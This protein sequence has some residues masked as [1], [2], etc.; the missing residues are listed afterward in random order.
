MDR[1]GNYDI[2]YRHVR[3][4]ANN[5]ADRLARR[6]VHSSAID[7]LIHSYNRSFNGF[8]AKLTDQ[9]QRKIASTEGVVSVFPS[10]IYKPL[11]TRSWDF[12]GFKDTVKRMPTIESDV[13]IGVLDT[14]ISPGSES[15]DDEGFGPPPK[16]W[17]GKCQ[18]SKN[19]ACNKKLIGARSYTGDSPIDKEGHGT[20][21]SSTAAG[22]GV[23]GA[24]LLGLAQGTARGAVPSARIAMYKVCGPDG[25]PDESIL[26][27]FDDAIADG[28]DILSVSLGLT[29]PS[30]YRNDSIAI[31]SF[32]AMNKGILT[33]QSAGNEGPLLGSVGS[34]A[35]WLLTVAATSTDRRI[36]NKIVL[37]NGITLVGNA[38]NTFKLNGTM[39]PLI[40]GGDAAS[41]N[42]DI[43]FARS[44]GLGCLDKKLVKGKIVFCDQLSDG[45]EPLLA[46]A[47]GMIAVDS[48]VNFPYLSFAYPL[49][50]TI[51]S[52]NSSVAVQLYMNKTKNPQANILKSERFKSKAP[53]VA[54]FSSRGPNSITSDILKPDLSAPG[55]E[56]LAAFSPVGKVSQVEEDKRSVKFS[57]ISGTSMACPHATGAAAYVMSFHP[58]WSPAAIKSALMTTASPMNSSNDAAAEFGY[59]AGN[60]DPVKAVHPGLVYEAAKD[61]YIKMLC[62]QGYT[63]KMVR[64][65][66][67]DMS[68]CPTGTTQSVRDLNYPSMAVNVKSGKPFKVN[69]SR[70]VT[71]VGSKNATYKATISTAS[72]LKITVTPSVLSFKSLHEKQH[73]ILTVA[74]KGLKPTSQYSISLVWSDGFHSVRSPIV[75]STYIKNPKTL[76]Q[77]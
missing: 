73:F 31:G 61:D 75:V 49:P 52:Q 12:L 23:K 7:F 3:R 66:S 59:G 51:L 35:P 34:L 62:A 74:G 24:S 32:H 43:K 46:G 14:G 72:Q 64:L 53:I 44:C 6:G 50:A 42:C 47:L 54:S 15:F 21:T 76:N 20:H 55:V 57:I 8:A 69:F 17:K 67:G 1:E 48:L 10:K 26:A 77:Q 38:I 9:E 30:D 25:C 22:R 41:S 39:F 45:E 63:T 58:D 60:I 19:F 36:E 13:I 56:I 70:V 37:G 33:S 29:S 71:N 68:S 5:E 2:S 4:S 40:S 65:I 11:T 16:K 27:A 18:S 28:V